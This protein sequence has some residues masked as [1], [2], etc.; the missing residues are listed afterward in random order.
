MLKL[1]LVQAEEAI[2]LIDQRCLGRRQN[3]R[4]V[5]QTDSRDQAGVCQVQV[6]E[7]VG[8][9]GA[10]DFGALNLGLEAIAYEGAREQNGREGSLHGQ[11]E[12]DQQGGKEAI[13]PGPKLETR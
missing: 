7:V 5:S 1:L 2:D 3:Q 12:Q 9:A 6:L 11:V 4:L 8:H 10:P 13:K